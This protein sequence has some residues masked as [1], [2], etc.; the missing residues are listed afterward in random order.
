M[1]LVND[2]LNILSLAKKRAPFGSGKYCR[3]VRKV[4]NISRKKGLSSDNAFRMGLYDLDIDIDK[5]C[6]FI[7]KKE[8]LTIQ[9]SVNPGGWSRLTED[10][11]QFYRYC[12]T[13]GIPVPSFYS[14]YFRNM[15]GWCPKGVP[16]RTE[17]HWL[18]YFEKV[19]EDEFVIKPARGVYG[20]KVNVFRRENQVFTDVQGKTWS[21]GDILNFMKNDDEYNV[22][23]IQER[24]HDHPD[25]VRLSDIK[26]IQT[27][28]ITTFIDGDG[29]FRF[30]HAALKI[31][32]GNCPVDSFHQ[33]RT[34]NAIGPV[35]L[36]TGVLGSTAMMA[37]DGHGLVWVEKHPR[38]GR[39]IK[40]FQLPFWK[41]LRDVVKNAAHHFLPIRTIGWDVAITPDGP[42]IIEAN[43]YWDPPSLSG[44]AFHNECP[45]DFPAEW[46][47]KEKEKIKSS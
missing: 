2:R 17:K 29:N 8:M 38:T 43:M 3:I 9:N 25:L 12:E 42:K 23:I 10:K 7:S 5:G 18:D 40:G 46:L 27:L 26:S 13:T 19:V 1:S 33:G 39:S 45:Y 34:G 47:R 15:D 44:C 32:T 4:W 14:V 21:A 6:P 28:R 31:I 22:Y 37:P 36:E 41:E 16:L 20:K 35:N 24:I 30:L 11:S